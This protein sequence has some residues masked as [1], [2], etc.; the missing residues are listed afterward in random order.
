MALNNSFRL[1][2]TIITPFNKVKRGKYN[3]YEVEI[4]VQNG[5]S[6]QTIPLTFYAKTAN[7][8][9]DYTRDLTGM[10]VAVGGYIQGNRYSLQDKVIHYIYMVVNELSI[11][12]KGFDDMNT[13]VSAQGILIPDDDLPF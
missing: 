1:I 13:G 11:I 7:P 10:Q 2:G 12:S 8:V 6:I 3:V 5:K 4:E 9:T